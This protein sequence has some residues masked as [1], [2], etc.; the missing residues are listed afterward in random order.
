MAWDPSTWAGIAPF[1][2]GQQRPNNYL[3]I[4][5]AVKD[6]SD[7]LPYAMRILTQGCCDGCAL[8]TTGLKDWTL[9]GIHLCNIRLRLLRLNT[10]GA[11]DTAEIPDVSEMRTM[12]GDALRDLGRIPRPMVRRA[13]E[14]RFTPLAW[15][16]AMT[17]VADAITASTPDRI[18]A[19]LTSR[20][21]PNETYYVAQKA[22]RALGSN[23][24]DNA[25]RVC[26]SPSTYGLMDALGVAATTC[27]YSDWIRSDLIVFFGSN[28][29][30]NQ[31]VATKYLYKAKRAGVKVAC[32]NPYREPGMDRYW[33][34][35]APES[36]L[37]GTRI[38]DRFFP[39]NI[40]GDV[41]FITGVLKHLIDRGWVDASFIDDHT[42]GFA[43]MAAAVSSYGWASLETESGATRLDME[44]MARLLHDADKAVFV[45]SMG[46]TQ[47]TTGED[48]VRAIVNLALTKGFVGRDG[49]G[50]MPI[51]GH[52]GVQGGAE[53]GC[54]ATAF[55]GPVGVTAGSAARLSPSYGFELS[56]QLGL[57][58][59]QMVDAGHAGDLDVLV[60]CGGNFREV[61]PDPDRVDA[62][63][64]RIG[65]RVHVDLVLSSQML[66]DPA[67]ADQDVI[68][69]PAIT[70]YE[71]PGG[72]TETSTERRIIFSPE[73]R[74]PRIPEARAEWEIF[75]DL[76]RRVRPERADA[77]G[78]RGTPAIRAEIAEV[79]PMYDG[80]QEL[81]QAGDAIQYGGP[82]LCAD[83][84]F[85]TEDGK[86]HFSVVR[87][88]PV[89]VPE[90]SFRLSTRRGKQFNSMVHEQVDAITGAPREAV[91]VA[92]AD[93]D[94]LGI[95]P[96]QAVV[97]QSDHGRYEGVAFPA[98]LRPGNLQVHWPEGNVLIDPHRRSPDA[99]IPDYNATVTMTA[100]P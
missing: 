46:I 24:I 73:I 70:R 26:H 6:N 29:A 63:L 88:E 43:D 96:G 58:A 71:I 76:V 9:D 31:P 69:L 92:R 48:N 82:H 41:A 83:W 3:E 30:N 54:Y 23:N 36:A 81:A 100:L 18:A 74:G 7:N 42:T 68:V 94:R 32:V 10:I 97:L 39:V 12:R 86:A 37:F 34:P 89:A 25:A 60:S 95:T 47:H 4:I 1:G 22:W 11:F 27:S 17:R 2:I 99:H 62:A 78:W 16:D 51:R 35:S 50:V 55:A 53:M 65:L 79:V 66:V 93:I 8:G 98:R 15:D 80:I 90:G 44:D 75:A 19:F 57:T 91:L 49:C 56:G 84:R 45:W 40:G 14:E 59:A 20:G 52:S 13:G 72:V 28:V 87:P 61:L 38:T 77:V 67:G 21:I 5:K 85:P 64:S 33:V